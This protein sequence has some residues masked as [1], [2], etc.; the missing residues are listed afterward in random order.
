MSIEKILSE[1]LRMHNCS[2]QEA[3]ERIGVSQAAFHKWLSGKSHPSLIHLK[4]IYEV[5]DIHLTTSQNDLNNTE[6]N[7][8]RRLVEAQ[9]DQIA[10]LKEKIEEFKRRDSNS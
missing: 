5:C 6:I 7:L 1:Y 8:L 2:Q 9:N 4:K 3:A 10:Y